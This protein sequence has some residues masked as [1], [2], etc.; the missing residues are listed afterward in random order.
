MGLIAIVTAGQLYDI[1]GWLDDAALLEQS[2]KDLT[3]SVTQF[4]RFDPPVSRRRR[5]R[6][7]GAQKRKRR[8]KEMSSPAPATCI[9]FIHG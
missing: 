2:S 8:R 9:F 7:K 6:R 5:K 3:N 4:N 1:S